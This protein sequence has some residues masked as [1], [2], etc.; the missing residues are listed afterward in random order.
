MSFWRDL[1]RRELTV[2]T[3]T[4]IL[5]GAL[6]RFSPDAEAEVIRFQIL[7]VESPTF[8]GRNFGSVGQYEKIA[9]RA[10]LEVDPDEEQNAK[11]VDLGL[12]PRNAGG[13]VEFAADVVILK[14]IDLAKGNDRIVYDVV[15][16]GRKT[17]L[18]YFNDAARSNDPSSADDAGNG[19]LMR[20]G[21]TVV[22]SGWQGNIVPGEDRM[23]LDV[24]VLKG[25]TGTN[26]DEIIF[27]HVYNP[28]VADLSYPA[29]DLDPS[30]ATLTVR[31]NEGDPRQ[32][33]SDL[34]FEYFALSAAGVVSGR[35]PNQ[36]VIHRPAGFDAGAIYEFT[37]PAHDPVVMGLAFASIRDVV[38]FLRRHA[39]DSVD[40]A[41][42]LAPNG[43]AVI[44][45]AYAFGSSQSGRLLRDFIYQGFNENEHGGMVFDGVIPHVAGSRKTFINYR[46]GQP[47]RFSRQHET[48]LTPGDQ[49]PFTYGVLTDTLTGKQDGILARCL[50]T[51]SCPKIFHT[52]TSTE[53]WQARSSLIVT[54]TNGEDIELPGNVRAYLFAG[55]PHGSSA[56]AIPQP[57]AICEGL[58][59][60]IH[61]GAPMRALLSA[62][63]RWVSEGIEPPDSRFPS[64]AEG[65]FVTPDPD[66]MNFPSIPGLKFSGLLNGLRLT[67]YRVWPP[68]EAEYYPIF[69]PKVDADGNDI[70]G[71]RLPA[72]A[73]P[74][75]SYLGW[76]HRSK[77]HAEEELCHNRGSSFPFS[78]TQA[79]REGSGD[80]RRSIEERY[81]THEVYVERVKSVVGQLMEARILLPED[82]QRMIE[83]AAQ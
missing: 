16:R 57:S 81:S 27:G 61:L 4:V 10:F 42:P 50:E 41:S 59:N 52:D 17:L 29:A 72:V 68:N 66:S 21:Y 11:I 24:P 71:I 48:H 26:H 35:R 64:H 8:E 28:F 3:L 31:Q 40:N 67:D 2:R 65:T 47:G 55:A 56:D 70:P 43:R 83:K 30:K 82:A 32:T 6:L 53:F 19:Y 38:S 54:D 34:S 74:R 39:F 7:E 22:W 20:E 51:Q 76:S 13:Q 80:S 78:E 15:N 73:V 5:A 23:G 33:P 46:W 75:A 45:Y 37:Y 49:F 63:D 77:G 69:V 79:G 9:A 58:S 18:R 60:P 12:A 25:L 14:P 44:R 36:I 1:K 62:L